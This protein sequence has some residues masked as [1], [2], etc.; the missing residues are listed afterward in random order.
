MERQEG[1]EIEGRGKVSQ[2]KDVRKQISIQNNV[3]KKSEGRK[4]S[5]R[6]GRVKRDVK[7][8]KVTQLNYTFGKISP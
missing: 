6:C 8:R 1:Q 4:C 3:K 7:R 5:E 2:G